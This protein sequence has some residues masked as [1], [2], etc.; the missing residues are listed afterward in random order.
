MG[1]RPPGRILGRLDPD[2]DYTPANCR[3][4]TMKQQRSARRETTLTG[5]RLD[6]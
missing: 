5:A 4:V 3:W 1:E 2:G 6:D